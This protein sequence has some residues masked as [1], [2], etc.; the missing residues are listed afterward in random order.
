MAYPKNLHRYRRFPT[1]HIHRSPVFQ[2]ALRG[3]WFARVH[4]SFT[5]SGDILL[6]GLAD[7]NRA[8]NFAGVG[9]IELSGAAAMA[10][11]LL[12]GELLE[13]EVDTTNPSVNPNEVDFDVLKVY[14]P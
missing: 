7:S 12:L 6:S 3:R 14:A 13:R 10:H 4:I 11:S 1:R 2:P 8:L 9:G 5:G